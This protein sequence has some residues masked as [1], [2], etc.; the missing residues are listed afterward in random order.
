M[1]CILSTYG[2]Y[3]CGHPVRQ[4]H[5]VSVSDTIRF[6]WHKQQDSWNR[7]GKYGHFYMAMFK[8]LELEKNNCMNY[9]TTIF[10]EIKTRFKLKCLSTCWRRAL[11]CLAW[12]SRQVCPSFIHEFSS[13]NGPIR[14]SVFCLR[15]RHG[16]HE[17]PTEGN[18]Y[19]MA[20]PTYKLEPPW[21]ICIYHMSYK[22]I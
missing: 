14:F 10:L 6:F 15:S 19:K 18:R 5:F 8:L 12:T 17:N 9:M 13:W 21:S 3:T 1:S 22:S 2:H 7:H 16:V 4:T 11:N 20:P